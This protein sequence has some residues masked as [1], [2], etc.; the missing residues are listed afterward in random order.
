ML[1]LRPSASQATST[2]GNFPTRSHLP[3]ASP[4]ERGRGG[5]PQHARLFFFFFLKASGKARGGEKIASLRAQ[6]LLSF[7]ASACF[8]GRRRLLPWCAW[9]HE[10]GRRRLLAARGG[11]KVRALLCRHSATAR[12]GN[13]P[14]F[15]QRSCIP[16]PP[17]RAAE[18]G[19]GRGAL[20]A[21]PEGAGERASEAAGE[22]A[23]RC[24]HCR[25]SEPREERH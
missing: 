18:R 10:A 11:E 1:A 23:G 5:Q 9:R 12:R 4:E 15:Q 22:E 25:L 20:T 8:S 16:H 13:C 7:L 6:P 19:E 24:C 14:T 2:S 17:S 3:A 21:G